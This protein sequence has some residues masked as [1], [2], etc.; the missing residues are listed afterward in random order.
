MSGW[1][2]T[3]VHALNNPMIQLCWRYSSTS[4]I[5]SVWFTLGIVC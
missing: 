3:W 2:I 4:L 1:R 5:W